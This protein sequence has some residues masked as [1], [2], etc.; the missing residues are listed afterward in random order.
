M[1]QTGFRAMALRFGN[2]LATG[3][4]LSCAL[5]FP[6]VQAAR[7]QQPA[8][9]TAQDATGMQPLRLSTRIV[10]L[11]MSVTDKKGNPVNNLT[12]DDFTI[13]EDKVPQVTR[14]F[15][16][17][18]AHV[19][20]K[21]DKAIVNSAADLPKIGN[22]PVTILVLDE[23]NTAFTDEAYARY[24]IERYL[25]AQP[26]IM[27]QPTTLLV[28]T[29]SKFEVIHDY[30][31]DR[32]ALRA[33]LKKHMPEIPWKMM[34]SGANSGGAAERMSMSLGSLYQI[35]KA[36]SGTPGRKTV[37][38][39]GLGFP[40]LDVLQLSAAVA[41][42]VQSAMKR[43]TQTLL[44]SHVT[45][46]TI[47]PTVNT[48][49][50]N[51]METPDDLQAAEDN[52]DGQ[53]F[54]DQV[55]FSTLA[56][57]TGGTALFSRNDID[58]EVATSISQGANYYTLSYSPTNKTNDVYKY[59]V[60]RI[61]ARDPNLTVVTR[62]GYYPRVS[63]SDNPFETPNEKPAEVK[64]QLN[65]DM[66]TAAMSTMPFSGVTVTAEKTAPDAFKLRIPLK[67]LIWGE[68][69]GGLHQ[70]EISVVVVAFDKK[71]KNLGHYGTELVARTTGDP[72]ANP[73]K[74]AAFAVTYAA[75]PNT[76]RLRFVVRDAVSGKIG[77]VE[78]TGP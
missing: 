6:A 45:L 39:V 36:S 9:A 5:G 62:D 38:W 13:F 52:A 72:A 47:D 43:L 46:F 14:S 7:A 40:N 70:A 20:P 77:T 56:P 78:L 59:R 54:N 1:V 35:A 41:D 27:P 76:T 37:I 28:A 12:R 69:P 15:E 18:S 75:P 22:A 66:T 68:Q 10:L 53:P 61:V 21:S 55:K 29:N 17:P 73:D 3:V 50:V 11:D 60:I 67:N 48:S 32:E 63:D 24:C 34:K 4:L 8:P 64:A 65:M 42:Q 26:P 57:A 2:A 33:A 51:A 58:K 49:T 44:E 30:T 31:Q 74:Q 71:D 23:L 19:M 25:N 16:P